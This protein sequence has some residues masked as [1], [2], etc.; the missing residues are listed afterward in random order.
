[1]TA[2]ARKLTA[3]AAASDRAAPRP[4]APPNTPQPAGSHR[5]LQLKLWKQFHVRLTLIYGS[6]VFLVLAAMGGAFYQR[7]VSSAIENIQARLLATAVGLAQGIEIDQIAQLR[8]ERDRGS[9]VFKELIERFQ[10][11]AD[12][13]T[14]VT[15]VYVL[16][17]TN[18]P[19][20]LAFVIDFVPAGRGKAAA[21]KIGQEYD[22]SRAPR[23]LDGL[24]GPVVESEMYSD[25]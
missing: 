11:I 21:A 3:E 12:A 23:M 1:M 6:A 2:P 7:G 17:P 5:A 19:K 8:D 22:A 18:K 20:I 9:P 13:E 4:A 24:K 10:A 25:E 14:D 15:S 16:R